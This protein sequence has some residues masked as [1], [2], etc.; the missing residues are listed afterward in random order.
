MKAG[1]NVHLK[2]Q[3]QKNVGATLVAPKV[4]SL[5]FDYKFLQSGFRLKNNTE[6]KRVT[7]F[8]YTVEAK[9]KNGKIDSLSICIGARER[10]SEALEKLKELF[11]EIERLITGTLTWTSDEVYG[12]GYEL[13]D[14]ANG[15][16]IK[17]TERDMNPNKFVFY[18]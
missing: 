14:Y 17:I 4:F 8:Q 5:K 10:W 1:E 11:P 16:E 15:R 6:E 7:V 13:L 9:E 18:I 2:Q 12:D 3:K